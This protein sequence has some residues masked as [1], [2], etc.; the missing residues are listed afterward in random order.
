MLI[1]ILTIKLSINY[2]I[3]LKINLK[4]KK[5]IVCGSTSGI[6]YAIAKKFSEIGASITL[7]SRDETKLIKVK[8][9][10]I[11][12]E[13]DF[14]CADFSNPR[15]LQNKI[16]NKINDT[17]HFDILI[18]NTGGPPPGPISEIKNDEYIDSINKHL[19][20]SHILF[21]AVYK[22][23]KK[24]KFGRIINIISTSVKEP[25]P[26]LG[27]SNITRSAIASWS[28]TLS[29]EVGKYG[30]TVN[31]ILPNSVN[32]Q[33]LKSLFKKL[34]IQ[35]ES[36]YEKIKEKWID[37]IPVERIAEAEKIANAAV[38]LASEYASYINGINLP[39]D[40]G[41]LNSL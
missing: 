21:K 10:L 24:K 28:K 6:G 8:N 31:N 2:N 16:K 34:A 20:C 35:E 26:N 15:I 1:Y 9:S 41:K 32:T 33:R 27:L 23:M 22:N 19:I 18:N 12:N 25:I 38:F 5:A 40:G 39:I 3:I 29:N 11:G 30:I 13:N 36:T 14:I 4:N 7:I 17:N 37:N